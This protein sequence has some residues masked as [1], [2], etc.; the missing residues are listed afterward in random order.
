MELNDLIWLS[1]RLYGARN[2]MYLPN[3]IDRIGYLNL[4]IGDLQDALRKQYEVHV[5]GAALARSV[6]RTFCIAEHFWNTREQPFPL[7]L[8]TAL[9][10]KYPASHCTYCHQNPCVCIERRTDATLVTP[11]KEQLQWTL[12]EWCWHLNIVYGERNRQRGIEDMVNRLFKEVSELLSLTMSVARHPSHRN[13]IE[14]EFALECAD[15]LA[16]TAA[17]ASMHTIDL[18][19]AFL[20]RYRD[21]CLQ[22]YRN[23][24]ACMHFRWDPINWETFKR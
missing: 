8:V 20:Q 6:S 10:Q 19:E 18:E 11:E 16:W 13:H 9:A 23:P 7:P 21:G 1:F 17:I 5:L 3:I 24:C 14:M 15:T 12:G 4:A 2:R 22:C